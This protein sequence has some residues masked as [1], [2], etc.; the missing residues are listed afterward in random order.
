MCINFYRNILQR[1]IEDDQLWQKCMKHVY[2]KI[3]PMKA[4]KYTKIYK[5]I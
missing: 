5:T 2:I 3:I 4:I 1:L